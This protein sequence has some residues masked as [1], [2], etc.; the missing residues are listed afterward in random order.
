MVESEELASSQ[1]R[2]DWDVIVIGGGPAGSTTARY[3]AQAAVDVLVIDGRDPIGT[4]LQCGELVPSNAEMKRLC[5][6]VPEMDDL[7]RTPD[8][9]IAQRLEEMHL[10]TP[11]GKRLKFPFEGNVLDRVAHDEALVQRAEQAGANYLTGQR[12][13]TVEG[14]QVRLRDG[15]IF[16]ARVIVGAGGHNDPIRRQHWNEESTNIPVKFVLMD[17]VHSE[18]LELHFGGLAPGG[19]AWVFPKDGCSN[20]GLGIQRSFAKD[21]SLNLFADDFISRYEGKVS[22]SGA[23]SLP[24]SG[25]ISSFVKDNHLLVGD[26]AGMVLPSNGAGITIAMI[27]GRIAAQAIASHLQNGTPLADYEAEWQRQMGAVMTNSKRAFRLGSIIFRLPDRLIDLAF[28]RL[29]KSF[30]WR[31]VT[32]RRMFWLF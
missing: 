6:D 4:P 17:G 9:A 30:L 7:F 10:V 13:E 5:P 18:A 15:R 29:T 2:S 20:I 3:L 28:N 23:G 1:P 26:A 11:S 32:C 31:G 12:V 16:T 24:M 27:G 22:Y 19:Y 25:T 8:S 14:E 21:R